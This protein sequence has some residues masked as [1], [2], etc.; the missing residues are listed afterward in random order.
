MQAATATRLNIAKATLERIKLKQAKA[1]VTMAEQAAPRL[2]RGVRKPAHD[3]ID[4]F[5]T[6]GYW[7]ENTNSGEQSC[8]ICV[9]KDLHSPQITAF[10]T[11]VSIEESAPDLAVHDLVRLKKIRA[12]EYQLVGV[13]R[14]ALNRRLIDFTLGW[15]GKNLPNAITAV[16]G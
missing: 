16:R 12:N 2:P 10:L 9:R 14:K 6:L 4:V 11:N 5:V 15:Q 8:A 1:M 7:A 13:L 3:E